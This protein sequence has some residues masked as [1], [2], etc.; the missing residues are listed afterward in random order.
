MSKVALFFAALVLSVQPAGAATAFLV[1]C[2]SSM[3]VTSKLI[4]VG[5]YQIGGATFQRYFLQSDVGYCP[6]TVEVQ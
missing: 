4:W 2:Q 3:S 6:T 5:T 1:S